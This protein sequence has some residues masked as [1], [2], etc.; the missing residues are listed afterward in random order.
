M[1]TTVCAEKAVRHWLPVS[2]KQEIS[3]TRL[4]AGALDIKWCPWLHR[5]PGPRTSQLSEMS[6]DGAVQAGLAAPLGD[7]TGVC[8]VPLSPLLGVA[9]ADG[10][11]RLLRFHEDRDDDRGEQAK[12]S[13]LRTQRA[14]EA[15][16]ATADDA[17]DL[18]PSGTAAMMPANK[19]P[20]Q[21]EECAVGYVVQRLDGF[22]SL[23]W[24][25]ESIVAAGKETGRWHSR[26]HGLGAQSLPLLLLQRSPHLRLVMRTGMSAA[27]L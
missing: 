25:N 19:G 18:L 6:I 23:S 21:L 10:S 26:S 20:M 11:I 7:G 12:L 24:S 2:A 5:Y 1:Q 9:C 13:A 3:S 16:A 27:G 8:V 15:K 22:D 4:A 17:C 14:H